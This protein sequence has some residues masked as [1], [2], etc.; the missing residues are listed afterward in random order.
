MA[1]F[2]LV[3]LTEQ[4]DRRATE[5]APEN[6]SYL[7]DLGYTLLLQGRLQEAH[8]IFEQ[9]LR[10]DPSDEQIQGNLRLCSQKLKSEFE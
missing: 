10:L 7:N 3:V 2:Y 1:W 5:L 6:A 4:H 8:D 9:A